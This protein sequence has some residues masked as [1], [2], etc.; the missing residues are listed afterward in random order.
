MISF[1][2]YFIALTSSSFAFLYS[3]SLPVHFSVLVISVMGSSSTAFRKLQD[4][5]G[6]LPSH[7]VEIPVPGSA[8]NLPPPGKVGIPLKLFD[9]GLRLPMT[10]FQQEVSSHYGASIQF[11]SPNAINKMAGFEMLCRAL[12]FL[13]DL[14]LFRYFFKFSSS[15]SSF[16]FSYRPEVMQF[17]MGLLTLPRDWSSK[18]LWVNSDLVG[19]GYL[20]R[21]SGPDTSPVLRGVLKEQASLLV[22]YSMPVNEWPEYVFAGVGMSAL[23]RSRGEMPVFSSVSAAGMCCCCICIYAPL[24]PLFVEYMVF[25]HIGGVSPL[26]RAQVVRGSYHGELKIDVRPLVDVLPPPYYVDPLSDTGAAGASSS[27]RGVGHSPHA[28]NSPLSTPRVG[29]IDSIGARVRRRRLGSQQGG[30]A[31]SVVI[32]LSDGEE[33]GRTP[34]D[35]SAA[36]PPTASPS[37]SAEGPSEGVALFA[38][39]NRSLDAIRAQMEEYG[40][41]VAERDALRLRVGQLEGELGEVPE[42]VMLVERLCASSFAMGDAIGRR[43]GGEAPGMAE[44]GPLDDPRTVMEMLL[45]FK[46]S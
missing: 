7:G 8:I 44:F 12:G 36:P 9:A 22:R 28:R 40:R 19:A 10:R 30:T 31:S 21:Y 43:D 33:G 16:N 42:F 17:L 23:W 6:F 14:L 39:A 25:C 38:E 45:S 3:L 29:E 35:P 5:Y 27:H 2:N 32:Q 24:S 1:D 26:A 4:R 41:V 15:G 37:I 18:W 34:E 20:R 13:P 46:R 11:L